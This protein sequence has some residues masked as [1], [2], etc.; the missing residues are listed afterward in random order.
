MPISDR[1]DQIKARH[2]E[3]TETVKNLRSENKRMSAD[4]ARLREQ[5]VALRIDLA[6][7]TRTVGGRLTG[8][9]LSDIQIAATLLG[10][11]HDRLIGEARR[12]ASRAASAALLLAA[13]EVSRTRDRLSQRGHAYPAGAGRGCGPT[14][15]AAHVL[16]QEATR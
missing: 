13:R 5:N 3:M 6:R 1:L 12:T 14:T 7:A 4:N 15:R 2:A 11:L 8:P 16:G 9:A 10:E